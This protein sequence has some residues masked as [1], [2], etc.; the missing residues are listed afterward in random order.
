M[1]DYDLAIIGGGINGTGIAR[2][3]AGRGIRVLL[4]EQS[5]LASGTSA[6][7]TKL[8]HG[9]LRYL[10]HGAFRLVRE[11]L[12]EREVLWRMAPHIIRP[13]R[14]V[15]PTDAGGRSPLLLRLGLWLYDRLGGRELL[16]P[17]SPLDLTHHAV[18]VPLKRSYRAALEYSDCRVDDAR[19]VV[20]N[21]VDAAERGAT[22]R[23]RTRC[24]RAEREEEWRLIL[25]ARGERQVVTA[26]VL[27]NAAGPWIGSVAETVLRTP[28]RVPAR[29]VKGSHIVV[30]RL[31]DHERGYIL[32]G[33]DRRF[34]F[35]LPFRQDFT[36]IGTTDEDFVGDPAVVT[37]S[38]EE[39]HYLCRSVSAYF[40]EGVGVEKVLHTYAG[41]RALYDDGAA[42]AKDATRDYRLIVDRPPRAA[43]LL[44]VYGGKITTYRRLAEA[45]L[46]L[47]KDRLRGG[48][49]WTATAPLP[50]GDFVVDGVHTLVAR[51]RRSWPFLTEPQAE[52]L[53]GAYGT[54][55]ARV[56]GEA[57]RADDVAPWFGAGLSG[58]EV[59]YLVK[60]EW[61]QTAD[62]VLWRRSKLGLSASEVDTGALTRFMQSALEQASV[63]T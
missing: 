53:V 31:F 21:A 15:L 26:S 28:L 58:A 33:P 60:Y 51:A 59:R 54:R 11:S 56:L 45:A 5:D 4:V 41:V 52:R 14:F 13:M 57:G 10:E 18:G 8:I 29:L 37:A 3:A 39:I 40:R 1:A 30:P 34:V 47:L 50:G 49:A 38:L 19:L 42:T 22:I 7:S 2:D 32:P 62:D 35:A 20:L 12:A 23:T 36:L 55:L 63:Q 43:P 27:I 25:K 46:R 24:V 17:T 44:T 61:A 48:P 6:A 16:P 9:G